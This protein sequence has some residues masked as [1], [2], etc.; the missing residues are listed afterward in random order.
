MNKS[1]ELKGYLM[2]VYDKKIELAFLLNTL[3][4]GSSDDT[5][6]KLRNIVTAGYVPPYTRDKF[7]IF[8]KY[9]TTDDMKELVGYQVKVSV[10][11]DKI[12]FKSKDNTGYVN[13]VKLWLESIDRLYDDNFKN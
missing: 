11:Y 7:T 3:P 4:N 8:C 1:I 13:Y 10:T 6:D 12:K 5:K 2:N 9:N